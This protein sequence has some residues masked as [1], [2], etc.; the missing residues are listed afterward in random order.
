[1]EKILKILSILKFRSIILLFYIY[2]F[3]AYEK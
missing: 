1:M 2:L 3:I